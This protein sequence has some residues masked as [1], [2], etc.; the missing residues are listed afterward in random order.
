MDL[1]RNMTNQEIL[2]VAGIEDALKNNQ[3]VLIDKVETRLPKFT[4][5][6]FIG[7][8]EGLSSSNTDVSKLEAQLLGWGDNYV[9]AISNSS[10][11]IANQLQVGQKI[12]GAIRVIDSFNTAFDGQLPRQDR[13]GNQLLNNGRP[14]Y[15]T[16]QVCT[17]DEL[18]QLGHSTIEVTERVGQQQNQPAQGVGS[19]GDNNNQPNPA[20][21]VQNIVGGQ[22]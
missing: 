18:N 14:I 12:D 1:N 22:A 2:K 10:T 7:K 5:L 19:Q 13:N 17:H 8:V 20:A 21:N 11:E 9:R 4:N 3:L 16:A 6:Y 15:R